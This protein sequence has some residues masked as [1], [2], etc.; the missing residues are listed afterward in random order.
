[1]EVSNPVNV[2]THAMAVILWRQPVASPKM[3][4]ETSTTEATV[5]LKV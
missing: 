1:M 5:A 3:A 4:K 2:A